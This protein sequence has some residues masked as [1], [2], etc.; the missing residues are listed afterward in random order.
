MKKLILL[1]AVILLL[2]GCSKDQIKALTSTPRTNGVEEY[3][4]TVHGNICYLYYQDAISCLPL[5]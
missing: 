4:D 3:V 1:L 5:N 2:G